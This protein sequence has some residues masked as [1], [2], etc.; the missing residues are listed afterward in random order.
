MGMSPNQWDR[1]K[2]LFEAALEYSPDQRTTFLERHAEDEIVRGEV[3]RL[4]A[5]HDSVGTFLSTPAFIDPRIHPR[6]P[7]E[8]LAPGTTL[9]ARFRVLDFIAAGGMGE[10]YQAED[11]H[12]GRIVVLKFLPKE[13]SE[14]REALERFRHEAKAASAL[15]HPN[16]C[17]VYDFGEDGGRAFIVMEYLEGESLS[18]RL[19]SGPLTLKDALEVAIDISSA[20]VVAHRKRL[21]HRDIKPSNIVLTNSGAKLLDFGVAKYEQSA[22]SVGDAED[23]FGD[24][25][26]AGTLSY[27]SPEQLAGKEV[28]ARTDI[29]AFGAVLYEMLTG[30][31]AVRRKLIEKAVSEVEAERLRPVREL[32]K[33]V[34]AEVELLIQRCVRPQP[35]ER[36]GSIGEVHREIEEC[37]QIAKEPVGGLKL[38]TFFRQ[39]KRPRVAVP[40]VLAGVIAFAGLASWLHR[41]QQIAWARDQALPQIPVLVQQGK[42]E[43]AYRLAVQAER[44]ISQNPALQKIWPDISWSGPIATNPEGASVYRRKY[45]DP[46]SPWEFVGRSPITNKRFPAID[47]SWKFELRGYRTT[48]RATFTS[49][50][51]TVTLDEI[52]K[53]PEGMVRVQFY[54]PETSPSLPVTL[55]GIAGFEALPTVSVNEFWIDKFEVTNADY[56]EF[57]DHGGYENPRYWKHAFTKNGR[58]LPWS[59]AMKFFVDSTGSPGPATWRNGEYPSGEENYP[60]T[61][62][63]WFE[64]AAYAEFVGKSLP[65][66]YHWTAAASPTDSASLIPASNF[67]GKGPAPVGEYK[68]M[69]WCGA[70][71]MAGNIKEW[72]SN[73]AVPGKRYLMGGAWNE[74]IYMFNDADARTPF[75]RSAEFGFRCAKYG[76]SGAEPKAAAPI[77]LK[78][79]DYGSEKPVSDQL[80]RAYK[81]IYLYDRT[82]LNAE[83]EIVQETTEWKAEKITFDA[84]YGGERVPA[85]LFLPKNSAPPYQAVVY[86]P[87]AGAVHM[88][89]SVK[90][91]SLF[92]DDLNFIIKSG[93]AVLFPVYKGTFERGGGPKPIYWPN[94]TSA[95]RDYLVEWSKDLGRSVDYLETRPDID[96]EKLAYLGYSWGAALGALLPA[97]E[98][99][100][101]A[102]VLVSPGL[103]LQERLPEVDQANFA[104]RVKTPVL[105]LNGRYDFIW[106]PTISQ[107][108]MF[109][110]LGTPEKDK[111]RIV[112]D[113]GHD[114]PRNEEIKE[115]LKWLDRYL[116]PVSSK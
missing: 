79:R 100:F 20:L 67:S 92:L 94:T 25:A 69:S 98:T 1:V 16:I 77:S 96:H 114:I 33:G 32:A 84:A 7:P 30:R 113:T 13:L 78:L 39:I 26:V 70:Y 68:G 43:E 104:P 111:R 37:Y 41:D 64:A 90:S 5:E 65:T 115:T 17:T 53:T 82:P 81:D 23:C 102:L 89:S 46:N 95:Y 45:A 29:F 10:V 101:K 72:C 110:L 15:N 85:F 112:Y 99:R 91:L 107:E 24:T 28:D 76:P 61:G 6:R 55:W 35:A 66:I 57:V 36:Y 108:P 54:G 60:V 97:I 93:R 83:V 105:M 48:E 19:K 63:S 58:V 50:P 40:L 47:S 14:D 62:V 8:R 12:L 44:F 9:A 2:Q 11:L 73:A 52:G 56:K 71:D 51:I 80:F 42:I 4:L 49:E 38:R 21:I 106:P 74:P 34:P 59:E 86:F 31:Q 116:G 27:M 103:Y 75:E 88:R 87:G 3:Q 22:T 109:R 18:T